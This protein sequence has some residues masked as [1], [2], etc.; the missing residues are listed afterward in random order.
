MIEDDEEWTEEDEHEFLQQRIDLLTDLFGS[1]TDKILA[2]EAL[3]EIL[4]DNAKEIEKHSYT[5]ELMEDRKV[6]SAALG[7][8]MEGI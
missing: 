7:N 8:I 1:F 5:K 4:K 3:N 2:I 6:I